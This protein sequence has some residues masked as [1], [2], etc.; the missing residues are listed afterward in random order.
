MTFIYK[1][2]LKIP[3]SNI[4]DHPRC[5]HKYLL[6]PLKF[7]NS[8]NSQLLMPKTLAWRSSLERRTE[9]VAVKTGSSSNKNLRCF[10]FFRPK[11]RQGKLLFCLRW[12]VS[13]STPFE[14]EVRKSN[15]ESF[16]PSRVANKIA[17]T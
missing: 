5:M 9:L 8:T 16:S 1:Y 6:Q 14:M 13:V 4:S 2:N 15:W 17:T 7:S 11:A 10:F 3:I 12:M